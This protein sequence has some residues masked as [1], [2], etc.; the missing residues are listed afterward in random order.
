MVKINWVKTS[1]KHAVAE[2]TMRAHAKEIE[3]SNPREAARPRRNAD[4]ARK[5]RK[6]HEELIQK[7]GP[8]VR[9]NS[10]L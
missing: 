4:N 5:F 6:T 1:R 7:H 3:D 10:L 9:S 8:T 2:R